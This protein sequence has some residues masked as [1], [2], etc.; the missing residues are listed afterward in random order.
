MKR[1]QGGWRG[2]LSRDGQRGGR[3]PRLVAQVR[4]RSALVVAVLPG[5]DH[6][7]RL[8]KGVEDLLLQALVLKQEISAS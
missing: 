8:P 1:L 6:D 7:L 3:S 2:K 5:S 4:V